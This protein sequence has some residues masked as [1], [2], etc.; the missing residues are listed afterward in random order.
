[1]SH[2]QELMREGE[3]NLG[4]AQTQINCLEET[5]EKLK[6]ELDATRARVRETSNLLTDLQVRTLLW[7]PDLI[8]G[9]ESEDRKKYLSS[10]SFRVLFRAVTIT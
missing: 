6:I 3:H 1:M 5:Q 8:R 4:S 7:G 9:Q 10:F 2:F